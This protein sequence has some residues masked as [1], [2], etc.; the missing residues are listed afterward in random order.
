M[1]LLCKLG[2]FVVAL[3][4]LLALPLQ[5]SPLDQYASTVINYSSQYD[6]PDWA[7][8][9]ALG[10]PDTFIYFDI[11]SAWAPLPRDGTLEYLTLGFATPVY[12][13][14]VT[15]RE[16]CGNGFVYQIDLVEPN[17]NYHTVWTGTDPSIP[18]NPID[19]LFTWTATNY[20]VSGVKIYVD[21]NHDLS[22]WEE[23][24]AVKLSGNSAPLPGTLLL[25]GSG[26]VILR[27]MRK[28]LS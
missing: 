18:G 4:L 9:Q 27:S 13:T 8:H 25:L 16:T 6:D 20:L 15:V 22:T 5:A 19:A 10:D 23:I 2:L 14:G 12:A 1:K 26:L 3:V 24:D 28:K 11:E 7:A 17:S 21:T